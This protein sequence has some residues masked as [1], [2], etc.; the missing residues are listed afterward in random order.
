MGEIGISAP[1]F[2]EKVPTMK[3][4]LQ[5]VKEKNP[6]ASTKSIFKFIKVHEY[7]CNQTIDCFKTEWEMNMFNITAPLY[8]KG[9]SDEQVRESLLESGDYITTK[10]QGKSP[11]I[12]QYRRDITEYLLKELLDSS[13]L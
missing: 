12:A 4:F 6:T 1:L 11:E 9:Y 10:I 13:H 2:I 8:I 7:I 5:K 3:L